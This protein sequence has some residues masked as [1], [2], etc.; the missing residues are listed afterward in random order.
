MQL[1]TIVSIA[2]GVNMVIATPVFVYK[3][4]ADKN[5]TNTFQWSP[6]GKDD[7]MITSLLPFHTRY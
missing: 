1:T 7:G 3:R 2:L 5:A 4:K 6:G